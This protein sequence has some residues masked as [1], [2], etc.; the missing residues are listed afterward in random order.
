MRL[1]CSGA[2]LVESEANAHK[3]KSKLQSTEKRDL[4]RDVI[5]RWRLFLCKQQISP[6]NS[7]AKI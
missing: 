1:S 7:N 2:H 4:S 6:F 3:L 5:E